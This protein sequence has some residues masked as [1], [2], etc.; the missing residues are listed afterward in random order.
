MVRLGRQTAENQSSELVNVATA[1]D[2]VAL[3]AHDIL[4]I[5]APPLALVDYLD[6]LW[7]AKQA[8]GE[9]VPEQWRRWLERW[10]TIRSELP[11]EIDYVSAEEWQQVG[12]RICN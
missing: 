5:L 2:P 8:K 7:A 1:P 3:A 4:L 6:R 10:K 9:T 11:S 12:E